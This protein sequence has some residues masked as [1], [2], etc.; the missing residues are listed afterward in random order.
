MLIDFTDEVIEMEP[1]CNLY[2]RGASEDYVKL[3][4]TIKYIMLNQDE[5]ISLKS[6]SFVKR[7]IGVSDVVVINKES[8]R[9]LSKFDADRKIVYIELDN[10]FW[11][12][13][14]GFCEV[15]LAKKAHIYVEFDEEEMHEE[16]N[17]IFSSEK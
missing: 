10:L 6:L 4:D 7:I 14:V 17:I 9:N 15:L 2:F 16:C 1:G 8:G 12:K 5:A 13:I 3:R 11:R